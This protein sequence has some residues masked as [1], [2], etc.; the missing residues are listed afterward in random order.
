MKTYFFLLGF[1][2]PL[3]SFGQ[4]NIKGRVIF[5]NEPLEG[6]AV[7]FNNTMLG[8]TTNEKG[9]FTLK[10]KEG[11][12]ELVVSFLGFETV[13]YQLD[14]N[15]YD[16]PLL[17]KMKESRNRL[18]EIVIKKIVYD[19]EWKYNLA[20]FKQEFLGTSELAK[21][22]EILNEEVLGFDFDADENK[23]VAF[24]RK[25]L[26]IKHKKL[27]YLITFDLESFERVKNQVSY[28]GYTRYAQLKGG[29]RKQKRWKEN[30]LKAFLGSP[31]HFYQALI[32]KTIKEDGFVVNQFRRV[33]N[34]ERPSAKEIEKARQ[35]LKLNRNNTFI[36]LSK[37]KPENY[38]KIDSA[39]AVLD[40]TRLPKFRDLL[41]KSRL[42]E[43]H[44]IT[45]EAGEY[46]FIFEDNISIVYKGELEEIGFIKRNPFAKMR[47]PSFQTSSIIP[48][49]RPVVMDQKGTLV[50]PLA[51]FYEGYWS[52]EKFAHSLP[53]DY[54]PE[55]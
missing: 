43:R 7:Y 36:D 6:A 29:K 2:L 47:E 14:T 27:G 4:I 20:S 9:E 40:K 32:N 23:L 24:A 48:L 26:Q 42:K 49:S 45:Q 5:E 52:Y 13:A 30:R 12:Y 54:L 10:T 35:L 25:P 18:D 53:L 17:F 1:F 46:K 38:T 19:E 22:C 8:T 33:E 28:L 21:Y 44:I 50:N 15:E 51:I 41:Y 39:W 31:L 34:P 16:K 3:F 55:K 11:V 37:K